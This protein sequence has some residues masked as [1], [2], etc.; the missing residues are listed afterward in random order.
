MTMFSAFIVY[1]YKFNKNVHAAQ[2]SLKYSRQLYRIT[3]AMGA[4]VGLSHFI[5]AIGLSI[6]ELFPLL[7]LVVAFFC[8]SNK[9]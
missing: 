9:L 3:T 1:H 2:V 5:L 7:S 8:S 6:T 4:T